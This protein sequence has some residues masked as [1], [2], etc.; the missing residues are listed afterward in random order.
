[1][2]HTEATQ[3]FKN[4]GFTNIISSFII[5]SVYYPLFPWENLFDPQEYFSQDFFLELLLPEQS[6]QRSGPV[7]SL[8][9]ST[10]RIMM[11]PLES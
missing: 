3:L 6:P 11:R 8:M 5:G 9:W 1:M 7:F 10:D 2:Q 4:S